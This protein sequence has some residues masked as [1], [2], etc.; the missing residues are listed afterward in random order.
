LNKTIADHPCTGPLSFIL[1]INQGSLKIF[2][3][4]F[5]Q[6]I[7]YCTTVRGPDI[8]RDLVAL[9]FDTFN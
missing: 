6:H 1:A 8:L 9:R 7:S 3:T 5:A 4:G 2:T